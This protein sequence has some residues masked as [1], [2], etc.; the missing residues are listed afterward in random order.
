MIRIYKFKTWNDFYKEQADPLDAFCH[1]M[2]LQ[3]A[4]YNAYKAFKK[5]HQYISGFTPDNIKEIDNAV[6]YLFKDYHVCD[7]NKNGVCYIEYE[8]E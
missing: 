7:W 5:N 2:T 3:E 4:Q 1:I 8:E 6:D